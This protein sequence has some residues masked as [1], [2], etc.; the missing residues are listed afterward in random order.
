MISG[1]TALA[2]GEK[3]YAH[4]A[5]LNALGAYFTRNQIDAEV[6][7]LPGYSGYFRIAYGVPEPAPLVSLLIPTRDRLDLLARCVDSI[8]EKTTYPNYEIIILDNESSERETLEYFEKI[9]RSEEHTSALQS[10]MRI[11]YA[12]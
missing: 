1:S 2:P 10:L 11:S 5:A 6:L 8:L 12:V 9:E 7:E 3:S 4:L